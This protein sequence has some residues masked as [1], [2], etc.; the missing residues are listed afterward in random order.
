MLC[1]TGGIVY[2][3]MHA[4]LHQSIYL[5]LLNGIAL[6]FISHRMVLLFPIN[7]VPSRSELNHH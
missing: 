2:D 5:A 7:A 6:V 4:Q 1:V 3:S